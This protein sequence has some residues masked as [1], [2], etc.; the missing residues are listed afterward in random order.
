MV[1]LQ[2]TKHNSHPLKGGF[3]PLGETY[4]YKN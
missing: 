4:D 3:I 1:T 2:C